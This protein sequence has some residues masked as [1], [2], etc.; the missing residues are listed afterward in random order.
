MNITRIY[1]AFQ[2]VKFKTSTYVAESESRRHKKCQ[3][4]QKCVE[5]SYKVTNVC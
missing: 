5:K 1:F 4:R 2:L 3:N